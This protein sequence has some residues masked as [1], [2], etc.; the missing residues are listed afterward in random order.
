MAYRC[1][2]CGYETAKWIGFCPQCRGGELTESTSVGAVPPS[3]AVSLST[4]LD[5][6]EVPYRSVG[7]PEVD[8]VLGGGLVPGSAILVG[9]EPGVGKSTLLLQMAGKLARSLPV[10]YVSAEESAPQVALRANRIG[11]MADRLLVTSATDPRDI[12]GAVQQVGPGLVVVDSVQTIAAADVAGSAGGIAQIR[13]CGSRLVAAARANGVPIALIGHVTKEGRIAGP[14]LLEHVVDAVLVLEGDHDAGLRV[15]RSVKNRHGS[16]DRVGVFEM[17]ETGL[18]AVSDPSAHLVGD[19][20]GGVPGTVLFPA[21]HGVRPL[22]VEIQALVVPST[23]PQPRRSVKGV[24]S[25]RVHQIL[26]VLERHAGLGFRDHEVYVSAVGGVRISEPASDLPIALALASS[27]T[28]T[29]VGRLAA[30]GEV[31]LTGELRPVGRA[32]VRRDEAHRLGIEHV[33]NSSSPGDGLV[34]MLRNQG[35]LDVRA[36]SSPSAA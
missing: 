35:F 10:L 9:G 17:R 22:L 27:R 23:A 4:V 34:A 12:V 32:G 15:L 25:A 14:K 24:D 11:A 28:G 2:D 19:W 36:R 30:F 13:E 33:A 31:G 21:I 1:A 6:S 26:A 20:V 3:P 18:A 29:P 7:M 5:A 16:V 8:R